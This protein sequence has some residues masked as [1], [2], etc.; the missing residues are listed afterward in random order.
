L[1]GN[2]S[3]RL[4][5]IA[6]AAL[7]YSVNYLCTAIITSNQTSWGDDSFSFAMNVFVGRAPTYWAILSASVGLGYLIWAEY[8]DLRNKK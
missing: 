6:F 3:K 2:L 7:L 5:G 8:E 4:T 1:K